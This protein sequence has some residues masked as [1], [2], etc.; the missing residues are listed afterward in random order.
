MND[1]QVLWVDQIKGIDSV[2][3]PVWRSSESTELLL[4]KNIRQPLS[5]NHLECLWE[6]SWAPPTCWGETRLGR[7]WRR[8][9]GG[10]CS[11]SC[12][13]KMGRGWTWRNRSWVRTWKKNLQTSA[14]R[15]SCNVCTLLY[16]LLLYTFKSYKS[17]ITY[18]E[19]RA[20]FWAF[21]KEI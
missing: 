20:C 11:P 6:R 13:A 19:S 2:K 14:S 17:W 8:R 12:K 7:A 1:P 5:R 4:H 18:D 21:Y 15:S 16:M 9:T 10:S 3:L